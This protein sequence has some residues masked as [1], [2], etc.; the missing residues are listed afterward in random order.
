[1]NN[2][3]QNN[4]LL[5]DL[6]G[7]NCPACRNSS[8]SDSAAGLDCT[9]CGT[10]FPVTPQGALIAVPEPVAYL[11]RT[12]AELVFQRATVS[13]L[14]G[15][16]EE[17]TAL[18]PQ[19]DSTR[20]LITALSDRLQFIDSEIAD[21]KQ[22]LTTLKA[23]F[24]TTEPGHTAWGPGFTDF[25]YYDWSNKTF[26][27]R[28]RATVVDSIREMIG[29][30]A[31]DSESSILVGGGAGRHFYD[32]VADH[33]GLVGCDLT[34]T[35]VDSYFRLFDKP[36]MIHDIHAPMI[37]SDTLVT[38]EQASLPE[39]RP[40][41]A[42]NYLV[43]N[44]LHLPLAPETVDSVLAIYFTDCVPLPTLLAEVNRLLPI[45]GTFIST[46]P[47]IYR[48]VEPAHWYTPSEVMKLAGEYGFRCEHSEWIELLFW[49][50]PD[51]ASRRIH[52]IWNYTLR[53]TADKRSDK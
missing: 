39:P 23:P 9:G 35:Y 6:P 24:P 53:K 27:V 5:P 18:R 31:S 43:A 22:M 33:P 15:S 34:Y 20:N 16:I 7:M 19:R 37:C 17:A 4:N 49:H 52:Q 1:M 51:K 28:Q 40:A 14:M 47:L 32:L 12:G 29:K 8:L 13:G 21:V 3:I 2:I 10:I 41:N 46:G 11:Q 26:A 36:M 25:I 38:S 48:G 50:S 30:Y 44:A 45:G 42:R